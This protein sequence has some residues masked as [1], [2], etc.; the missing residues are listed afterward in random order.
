[1]DLL[2]EEKDVVDRP[3][4]QELILGDGGIK[5]NDVHFAYDKR[6]ATIK[7]ISFE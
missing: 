5:F 1:M 6:Q 4:A 2:N 7:G 3:G